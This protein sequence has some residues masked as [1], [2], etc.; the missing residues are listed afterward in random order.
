MTAT[1]DYRWG[2][3]WKDKEVVFPMAQSKKDL[4]K[5]IDR[6]CRLLNPRVKHLAA[7]LRRRDLL[8]EFGLIWGEAYELLSKMQNTRPGGLA[9]VD[10]PVTY[11]RV[12][13]LHERLQTFTQH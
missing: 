8:N 6:T 4:V 3:G 7:Q 9:H 5:K 2:R 12:I 10:H 1:W 13:K 11:L